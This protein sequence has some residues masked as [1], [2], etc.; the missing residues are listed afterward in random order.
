MDSD[1]DREAQPLLAHGTG[2]FAMWVP[3]SPEEVERLRLLLQ[4]PAPWQL[5]LLNMFMA[6]GYCTYVLT[7]WL[8]ISAK[9]AEVFPKCSVALAPSVCKISVLC[10]WLL[11]ILCCIA[12][13]GVMFRNVLQMRL[14]YEMQAYR[15]HLDFVNQGFASAL[16][17]RIIAATVLLGLPMYCF[18]N[19]TWEDLLHRVTLTVPY[20]LP[21][22]SFLGMMYAYWDVETQLIPLAKLVEGDMNLA[23]QELQK[24]YLIHDW[25]A[26][27][28]WKT[29]KSEWEAAGLSM[30]QWVEAFTTEC[31][32]LEVQRGAEHTGTFRTLFAIYNPH[33]WVKEILTSPAIMTEPRA[34]SFLCWFR[35]FEL[36]MVLVCVLLAYLF[37]ATTLTAF[38]REV[39]PL[40]GRHGTWWSSV[41]PLA[42]IHPT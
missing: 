27:R 9:R 25:A 35:V 28:A 38:E 14:Y 23:R 21:I 26:K 32:K 36:L 41:R 37:F 19:A 33:Y 13:F 42:S 30:P 16:V 11:P 31:H 34:R 4:V 10:F 39:K 20:W 2:D 29:H 18:G 5:V 1:T 8:Y 22:V 3:P 40:L 6:L 7:S 24:A 12:A 17:V 15:L